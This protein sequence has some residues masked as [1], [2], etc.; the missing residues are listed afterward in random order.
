MLDIIVIV[1][2]VLLILGVPYLIFR[3]KSGARSKM[4]QT[5]ASETGMDYKEHDESLDDM[6]AKAC[7]SNVLHGQVEGVPMSIYDCTNISEAGFM[8]QKSVVQIKAT[9][10]D[11]E[12]MRQPT[13][14]VSSGSRLERHMG[15]GLK[16]DPK[17]DQVYY[18]RSSDPTAE[19]FLKNKIKFF[20][21]NPMDYYIESYQGVLKISTDPVKDIKAFMGDAAKIAANLKS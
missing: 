17:F 1:L 19:S 14:D 5:I 4:F 8:N 18:V 10:P 15:K 13:T 21:D 20:I 9:M 6:K 11:F 7:A 2:V 12:I 3:K 16:L